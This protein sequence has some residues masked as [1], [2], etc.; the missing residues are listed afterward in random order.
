MLSV[1]SSLARLAWILLLTTSFIACCLYITNSLTGFL[2]YDVI[3]N[4]KV[5]IQNE[6]I[7]PAVIICAWNSDF[8][9]DTIIIHCTFNGQDC[10]SSSSTHFEKVSILGYGLLRR[11]YCIKFNRNRLLSV[12]KAGYELGLSASFLMPSSLQMYYGVFENFAV[13]RSDEIARG[14]SPGKG[15]I[16]SVKKKI[17]KRLPEPYN[18]CVENVDNSLSAEI[19]KMGSEYRQDL[20][21]GLCILY[22]MEKT[23]DCSLP[24]QFGRGGN[25]TCSAACVQTIID[26]FDFQKNCR[27][28]PKMCS[29]VVYDLKITPEKLDNYGHFYSK[30]ENKLNKTK[31]EEITQRLVAFNINFES[32][33]TE[34]IEEMPKRTVANLIADLGGTFGNLAPS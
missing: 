33:S 19:A 25:D 24:S 21:Y 11:T 18:D 7:F 2:A 8:P 12:N 31:F 4:K 30:I 1:D 14:L 5:Q 10:Q 16:I 9:I 15:Y 6:M 23:C 13:I 3:S 27:L 28:C 17:S 29:T 34:T 22:Y 20:C 26:T 32:L